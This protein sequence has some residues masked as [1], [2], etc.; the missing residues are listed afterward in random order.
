MFQ[1]RDSGHGAQEGIP[2]S[3]CRRIEENLHTFVVIARSFEE[4]EGDVAISEGNIYQ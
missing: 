3:G 2:L 4:V 1:G